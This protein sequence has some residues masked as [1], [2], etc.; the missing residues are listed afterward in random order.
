MTDLAGPRLACHIQTW[1]AVR[2]RAAGVGS[3]GA[4]H[5]ES[6]APLERAL[7]DIGL[8]GFDG[9]EVFDGDLLALEASGLDLDTFGLRL[10]GVYVGGYLVFD[11]VWPEERDRIAATCELAATY[12]ARDVVLGVGGIRSSG[13]DQ[14][15]L[16]RIAE[17]LDL[18]SADASARGLR[19]HY[20]PHPSP[21]G[22]T[23]DHIES[24]LGQ[25]SVDVCPDT[26]VLLAGA[27]D[28]VE[29]CRRHADR[30]TYAHLKDHR[31]GVDVE[32]GRGSIDMR[33]IVRDLSA[34]GRLDWLVTELDASHTAAVVSARSMAT[35]VRSAVQS[36]RSS[37]DA[38]GGS[39]GREESSA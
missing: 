5:F 7:T 4:L 1:G 27:V 6:R 9:V 19:A 31:N 26:A 24:V 15:D 28:P 13:V 22:H 20:H 35:F 10:S 2:L 11:D 39:T 23:P 12:G 37:G 21:G 14:D 29:F 18:L 25:T 30:I 34:G 38:A 33:A 3:I 17:R 16:T 32:V 36:S 8:V